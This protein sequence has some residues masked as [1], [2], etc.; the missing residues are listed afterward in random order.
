MPVCD[1]FAAKEAV[2]SDYGYVQLGFY[3]F[4]IE[5][6][7]SHGQLPGLGHDGIHTEYYYG[8]EIICIKS[9]FSHTVHWPKAW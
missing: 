4:C 2:L 1:G 6:G 5:N 7:L 8:G 3:A 9:L